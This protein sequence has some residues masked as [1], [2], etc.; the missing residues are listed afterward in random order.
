MVKV[1]RYKPG[2]K[3]GLCVSLTTL[4]P[5]CAVVVKSRNVNFLESSG[6]LQ[7][8]TLGNGSFPG[9]RCGRG[10]MLTPHPLLM[11]KSKIE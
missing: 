4:P 3:G 7:A 10:V 11:P 6:P 8:C 2:G 9:V 1:L 5:S